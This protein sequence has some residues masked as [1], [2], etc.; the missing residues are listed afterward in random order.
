MN[1][2]GLSDNEMLKIVEQNNLKTHSRD[3]VVYY[4]NQTNK[5]LNDGFF[6][7]IETDKRRL[8]LE[9]S[10]HKYFNW[11]LNHRQTNDD[12]F[13]FSNAANT[14]EM[15]K[16]STGI[17][18]G[19][20]KVT[21]YEIGLNLNMENDCKS[22]I[23]KMQ[24]I[25]TLG[26]KRQFFVNPKYKGERIKTT[27]FHRHIK[28]VY[29]VYDK[30]HEMKDKKSKGQPK[31]ENT[32]RI[33][34]IQKRVE[35]MTV[36]DLL[37]PKTIAKLTDQF[38]KDWRTVQFTPNLQVKKGTHQRKVD[39]CTQIILFGK[40]QVLQDYRELFNKGDLTERRFRDIREFIQYEW[41]IFKKSVVVNK[42]P[43]EMEFRDKI[44]E[45][46]KITC[47]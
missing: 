42:L 22:Y 30:N 18:V 36:A 33:E 47:I 12:L 20:L 3:G 19:K 6:L 10:L 31:H 8:K 38:L 15:L 34:T 17:D 21:Y 24:F 26:N 23:D 11:I 13:S 27:I 32:L 14:I 44:N 1:Q 45:A 35:R 29:K 25:G 7:R 43:A 46:L 16:A 40:E 5:S 37:N 9:C 41:D 4:D 2:S 39:L 28:K